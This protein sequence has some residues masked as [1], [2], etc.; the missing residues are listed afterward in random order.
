VI[1]VTRL[2]STL[3]PVALASVAF[4]PLS[5]VAAESDAPRRVYVELF[6]GTSLLGDQRLDFTPTV[7][8]RANGKVELGSGWLG[9]GAVGYQ[10]ADSIRVEAEMA[11]RRNKAKRA[12]ATGLTTTSGG[13]YAS[14]ILMGNALLDVG[15]FKTGFAVFRPYIGAG[16]GFV[17]EIDIDLKG[18]AASEFDQGGLFAYQIRAGLRWQY[19]SG[20]IAGLGVRYLKTD[21][22]KMK[23]PR[24]RLDSGYDPLAITAS[25]GWRF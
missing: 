16:V 25:V 6:G 19:E 17:E 18:G 5:A 10:V 20:A 22:P 7:G 21:T 8:A 3:A 14:L 9:G 15:R 12:T 24:G 4:F 13:D 23:G 1:Y 11:Y 2:I